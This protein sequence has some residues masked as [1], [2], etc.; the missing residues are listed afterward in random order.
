MNVGSLW[1]LFTVTYYWISCIFLQ[2]YY[3]TDTSRVTKFHFATLKMLKKK[4]SSYFRLRE[5]NRNQTEVTEGYCWA[6]TQAAGR[7]CCD[8][9]GSR[10]CWSLNFNWT[11]LYVYIY[12]YIY[13]YIYS[14]IIHT[15]TQF[16]LVTDSFPNV[17]LAHFGECLLNE[18]SN[19]PFFFHHLTDHGF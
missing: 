8:R 11:P 14:L 3:I 18:K 5:W 16:R 17:P 2:L 4:R 6:I 9:S 1:F 13:I 12:I 19:I 10:V 15:H 7:S